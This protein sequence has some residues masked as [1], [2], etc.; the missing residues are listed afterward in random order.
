MEPFEFDGPDPGPREMW[1][2][3]NGYW[4]LGATDPDVGFL[5]HAEDPVRMIEVHSHGYESICT[6]RQGS[7]DG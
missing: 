1:C 5:S 3:K 6:Y 2:W 4:R 7:A